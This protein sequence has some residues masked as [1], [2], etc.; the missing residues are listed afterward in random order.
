LGSADIGVSSG[1][2]EG[3]VRVVT[4]PSVAEMHDGEILVVTVC[5]NCLFPAC[6]LALR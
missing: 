2:V 3:I 5:R 6:S 1:A 4:D